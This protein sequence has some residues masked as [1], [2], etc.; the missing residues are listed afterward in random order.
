MGG[1]KTLLTS[2]PLLPRGKK[3]LWKI[4]LTLVLVVA[5]VAEVFRQPSWHLRVFDAAQQPICN[6]V[7]HSPPLATLPLRSYIPKAAHVLQ[8]MSVTNLTRLSLWGG[9][10]DFC[11]LMQMLESF[12]RGNSTARENITSHW[13]EKD[14]PFTNSSVITDIL[15]DLNATTASNT[16]S[17]TTKEPVRVVIVVDISCQSLFTEVNIGTGNWVL[18]LYA[19]RLGALVTSRFGQLQVDFVWDCQDTVERQ[20]ELVMPWLSGYYSSAWIHEPVPE[21][22]CGYKAQEI[23]PND[24]GTIV[25]PFEELRQTVHQVDSISNVCGYDNTPMAV[26]LPL[27]RYELRRMAVS[28]VGMPAGR[29]GRGADNAHPPLIDGVFENG[30]YPPGTFLRLPHE[31]NATQPVLSPANVELD[32]VAIHFPCGDLMQTRHDY[33]GFMK[34][35]SFANRIQNVTTPFSIGILT[36]PFAPEDTNSTTSSAIAAQQR[37]VDVGGGREHLC[38]V[39]THAFVDYLQ[40]RF[41]Q[42]RI[43]IRNGPEDTVAVSFARLI[44]AVQTFSPISSFSIFPALVSMGRGYVRYPLAHSRDNRWMITPPLPRHA[45]DVTTN[46][47]NGLRAVSLTNSTMTQLELMD[48]P[49]ILLTSQV[50]AIR[51]ENATDPNATAEET[52]INWFTS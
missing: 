12:Q 29:A 23:D 13:H 41:P 20:A 10:S 44:I 18:A 52:L 51:F 32:D 14:Y 22:E 45:F 33:Y 16:T 9:D 50:W 46:D 31:P 19:M 24:N 35:S 40:A 17:Q 11:H 3:G 42:A 4:L 26:M 8:V 36:Q 15:R 6:V 47:K 48:D 30:F 49:D 25:S 38:F 39:V 7:P 28:L 1:T 43:R 37:W 27:M 5:Q 34:F 21:N 2:R